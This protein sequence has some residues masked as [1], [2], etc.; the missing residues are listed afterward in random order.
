MEMRFALPGSLIPACA[1]PDYPLLI[2]LLGWT[3]CFCEKDT[4]D[5]LHYWHNPTIAHT[6]FIA[7]MTTFHSRL[8]NL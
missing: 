3:I 6:D 7:L 5:T 8:A 2:N 4:G 1:D